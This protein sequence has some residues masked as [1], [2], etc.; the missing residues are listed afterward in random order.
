[1]LKSIF[2]RSLLLVFTLF[3][4]CSSSPPTDLN[5]GLIAY[6]SFNDCKAH[7]LVGDDGDGIFFGDIDCWCGIEGNGL[8]LD[9]QNDYIEFPGSLNRAFN[10]QD[11][12]ISF[13]VKSEN[14]SIFPSS[15]FSKRE[16]CDLNQMLD[17]QFSPQYGRFPTF[18]HESEVRY[19]KDLT[20][21]VDSLQ[22]VHYVLVREGF[23]AQTYING[24]LQRESFKCRGVDISNE[25]IFSFS[26]SP[27]I[28]SG[29]IRRFKG[30]LDEL[31]IYDR[32]LS[33]AEVSDLYALHP[34]D[35]AN[36]N[37]LS[38]IEK[39]TRRDL[40][41]KEESVYLCQAKN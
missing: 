21:S 13:Y 41:T 22:W 7:N 18:F 15:L 35:R 25:A 33:Q 2:V 29:R 28:G 20:P 23:R 11:F 1:M 37:C 26:N 16:Q 38:A 34:V 10:V 6:Y 4:L 3:Q 30:I 27:C 12:T 39:N 36:P 19:F 24:V 17:I 8:L 9:G 40:L 32:A 5:K 31:R 14:T